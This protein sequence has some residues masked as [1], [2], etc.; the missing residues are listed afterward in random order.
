MHRRRSNPVKMVDTEPGLTAGG[1]AS[2]ST[3]PRKARGRITTPRS[4]KLSRYRGDMIL[5]TLLGIAW[6]EAGSHV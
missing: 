6:P 4:P 2:S 1:A 3:Q 5:I